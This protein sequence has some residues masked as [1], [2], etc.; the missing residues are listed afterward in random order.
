MVCKRSMLRGVVQSV[1]V[2]FKDLAA[3][4]VVL[5]VGVRDSGI[6]YLGF[7]FKCK[8]FFLKGL[9][10]PLCSQTLC[11]GLHLRAKQARL[12]QTQREQVAE[13]EALFHFYGSRSGSRRQTQTEFIIHAY[14]QFQFWRQ[15]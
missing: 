6:Q 4:V 12:L 2:R 7:G 10:M 14:M 11:P 8:S 15:C 13:G 5:Q 9:H 3:G 1:L